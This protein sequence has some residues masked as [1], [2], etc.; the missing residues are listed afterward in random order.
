MV[1]PERFREVP[2][3]LHARR[4]PEAY[5]AAQYADADGCCRLPVHQDVLPIR[6]V[7]G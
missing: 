1:Q 6:N 2:S 5:V 7:Q 4:R 3:R